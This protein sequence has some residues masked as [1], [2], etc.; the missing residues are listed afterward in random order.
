MKPTFLLLAWAA[1]A[2]L[3]TACSH[4]EPA[5]AA[6][7]HAA[8]SHGEPEAIPPHGTP[9]WN[10]LVDR[11]LGVTDAAGHGPDLGSEEWMGAVGKKAGITGLQPGSKEWS[12][13]VEAKVFGAR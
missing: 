8:R 12:R 9:A 6:T 13:A 2:G 1:A 5:T 3:T 11:R 4:R 7:H 10:Q